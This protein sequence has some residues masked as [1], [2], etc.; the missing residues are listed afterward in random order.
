MYMSNL[1]LFSNSY[2]FGVECVN[3]LPFCLFVLTSFSS[4]TL[5]VVKSALCCVETCTSL[6]LGF[7]KA[8]AMADGIPVVVKLAEHTHF[9]VRI[10]CTC[11]IEIVMCVCVFVCLFICFVCL[12]VCVCVCV[13]G[14]MVQWFVQSIS[15]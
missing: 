12:S 10:R 14:R 11:F 8:L 6:D 13:C 9:K 1:T 7:A 3:Y 4:Q 15:N 5:E 2:K